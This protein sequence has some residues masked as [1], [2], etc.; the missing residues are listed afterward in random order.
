MGLE[1]VRLKVSSSSLMV[2]LTIGM[3][4][5]LLVSPLAKLTVMAALLKSVVARAVPLLGVT[6]TPL[7]S[8]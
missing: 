3:V 4:T 1:R 7:V 8:T 5:V 2:S 6:L